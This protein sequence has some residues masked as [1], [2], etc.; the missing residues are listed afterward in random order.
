[1]I[2]FILSIFL[3]NLI[4]SYFYFIGNVFEKFIKSKIQPAFKIIIGF[5]FFILI[6]YYLY[7]TLRLET[8]FINIFFLI[9]FA[10]LFF[11]FKS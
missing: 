9:S 2:Q 3:C 6:S 5:S 7:F 4:L 8:K 1:M 11:F 10:F